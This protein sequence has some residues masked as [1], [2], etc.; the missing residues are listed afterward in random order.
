MSTGPKLAVPQAGRLDHQISTTVSINLSVRMA[1]ARKEKQKKT[2]VVTKELVREDV[3]LTDS[4]TPRPAPSPMAAAH[5]RRMREMGYPVEMM[6]DKTM[7]KRT[8]RDTVQ[9]ILKH[10]SLD[11]QL[12]IEMN[13]QRT[14]MQAEARQLRKN[15][16]QLKSK[17]TSQNM[18]ESTLVQHSN[19]ALH[20]SVQS[21]PNGTKTRRSTWNVTSGRIVALK[22]MQKPSRSEST[23]DAGDSSE[24]EARL[25]YAINAVRMSQDPSVLPSAMQ[26]AKSSL[27]RPVRRHTVDVSGTKSRGIVPKHR[28]HS[29]S[30]DS[31]IS[32]DLVASFP[33]SPPL[34]QGRY[35]GR[36]SSDVRSRDSSVHSVKELGLNWQLPSRNSTPR[37]PTGKRHRDHKPLTSELDRRRKGEKTPEIQVTDEKQTD[38]ELGRT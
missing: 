3:Y 36:A 34:S 14:Q 8:M 23:E 13:R 17:S 32:P 4:T 28:W 35:Q 38:M 6:A 29:V 25:C 7:A 18:S 9:E 30:G 37:S 24:E 16:R 11:R 31:N 26:G 21:L 20:A 27:R 10:R 12:Q 19:R 15:L 22:R 5:S 1:G 2:P 33:N